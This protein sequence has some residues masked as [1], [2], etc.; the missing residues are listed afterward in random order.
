MTFDPHGNTSCF[1]D[2]PRSGIYTIAYVHMRPNSS[3]LAQMSSKELEGSC[4]EVDEQSGAL[5]HI[6]SQICGF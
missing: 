6:P 3:T 1:Y 2:K 5:L 4:L